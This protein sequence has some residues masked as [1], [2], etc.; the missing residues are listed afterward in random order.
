MSRVIIKLLT[1]WLVALFAFSCKEKCDKPNDVKPVDWESFNDV[2]TVYWNFVTND[3]N[4][5]PDGKTIKVC[6]WV[7]AN[8]HVS[9][10]A[11]FLLYDKVVA[12]H[13]DI[14]LD[15]SSFSRDDMD[16]KIQELFSNNDLKKK[17]YVRGKLHKSRS[18]NPHSPCRYYPSIKL[19]DIDD[20]YFED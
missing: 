13:Y 3:F 6:G 9:V 19:L 11:G 12:D 10:G 4:A 7:N 18:G 17:C 5:I 1:I 20:F 14:Y 2:Y 16:D 15:V 8:P